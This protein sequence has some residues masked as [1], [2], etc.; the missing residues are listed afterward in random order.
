MTLLELEK[1]NAIDAAW[2][3]DCNRRHDRKYGF[4]IFKRKLG[5]GNADSPGLFI[6]CPPL[7]KNLRDDELNPIV[8]ETWHLDKKPLT[9]PMP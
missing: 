8:W 4:S 7:D 6:P 9:N 3:K 5:Y 2:L 1:Q